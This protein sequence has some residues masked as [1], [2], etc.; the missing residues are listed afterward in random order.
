MR[1]SKQRQRVLYKT[2]G[3]QIV[4]PIVFPWD[5]SSVMGGQGRAFNRNCNCIAWWARNAK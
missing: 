3:I 2:E 1:Y 5:L 4:G